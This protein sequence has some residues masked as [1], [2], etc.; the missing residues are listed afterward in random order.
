MKRKK[1][2]LKKVLKYR[3]YLEKN[4]ATRFRDAM[5]VEE[6]IESALSSHRENLKKKN[7]RKDTL[8]TEGKL[9]INRIKSTQEEILFA[10]IDE[11]VLDSELV[12]ASNVRED[13]RKKWIEKKGEADAIDKLK[14]KFADMVKKEILDEDQKETDE[15]ARQCFIKGGKEQ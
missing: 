14:D 9:D 13:E 4:Q 11:T 3:S 15:I 7:S 12:K 2:P 1:F 5:H 8:I 10:Q 6:Y